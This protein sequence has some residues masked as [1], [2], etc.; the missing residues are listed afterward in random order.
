MTQLSFSWQLLKHTI[1][2]DKHLITVLK[3]LKKYKYKHNDQIKYWIAL[4]I[5]IIKFTVDMSSYKRCQLLFRCSLYLS[6]MTVSHNLFQRRSSLHKRKPDDHC[7]SFSHLNTI[8]LWIWLRFGCR[9][10][11]LTAILTNPSLCSVWAGHSFCLCWELVFV[12]LLI[13]VRYVL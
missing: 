7:F 2:L 10:K 3:E 13:L 1:N 8:F 5:K 4:F 9:S 12:C 11:N 6:F